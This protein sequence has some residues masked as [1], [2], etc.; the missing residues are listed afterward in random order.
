MGTSSSV[1]KR[2][3][4]WSGLWPKKGPALLEIDH[5][6]RP[7]WAGLWRKSDV[8]SPERPPSLK[9]EVTMMRNHRRFGVVITLAVVAAVFVVAAPASYAGRWELK[10][11]PNAS[12]SIKLIQYKYLDKTGQLGWRQSGKIVG[13]VNPAFGPDRADCLELRLAGVPIQR[14]VAP[15]YEFCIDLGEPVSPVIGKEF[16]RFGHFGV[17]TGLDYT[18]EAYVIS[19]NGKKKWA[20]PT[21]TFRIDEV[22][23]PPTSAVGSPR[24]AGPSEAELKE[25]AKKAYEA[26]YQEG[27]GVVSAVPQPSVGVLPG[28]RP[29][30]YKAAPGLPVLGQ[31]IVHLSNVNG[32]PARGRVKVCYSGGERVLD[33][34]G[35]ATL[36]VPPGPVSIFT[37][38]GVGWM[39]KAGQS[40]SGSVQAGQMFRWDLYEGGAT[41]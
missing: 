31:V 4:S 38:P 5:K 40:A 3:I 14:F 20:A 9:R 2:P 25:L 18:I 27:K 8:G 12:I 11:T 15:P 30:Y 10:Y 13:I 34:N 22:V 19:D 17:K 23:N 41:R 21:L 26:G 24:E 32:M 37:P 16:E 39:L 1:P 33:V 35:S 36:D 6:G 28:I 29:G 7:V